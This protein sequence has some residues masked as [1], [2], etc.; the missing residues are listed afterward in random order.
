MSAP[1][2]AALSRVT[3][4]GMRVQSQSTLRFGSE[5]RWLR[6]R[7]VSASQFAKDLLRRQ[8][9]RAYPTCMLSM[10]SYLPGRSYAHCGAGRGRESHRPFPRADV[11][12]AF[13]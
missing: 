10:P 7:V 8:M 4:Q 13:V 2:A 9:C 12:R 5:M 1:H 3:V 11:K 6:A